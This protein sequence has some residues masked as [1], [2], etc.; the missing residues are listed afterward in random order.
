MV[1]QGTSVL[2]TGGSG[3]IG[4][5]VVRALH[6]R[7]RVLAPTH[8]ELDLSDPGATRAYLNARRPGAVVHCAVKP[9]HRAALD[10]AR[11]L[12]ANLRMFMSLARCRDLFGRYIVVSSG[13]VYDV[14]RSLVNAVEDDLGAVVPSDEHGVSKFVEAIWLADDED[15]VELRPFGVYGP[16]ED[17]TIR[18]VSNAVCKALLGLPLTLRQDRRFSYVWVEDLAAVILA[19]LEGS[20]GPGAYNVTS[21]EDPGLRKIADLVL[22]VTDR[23]DLPI[24]VALEDEGL[25]YTGSSRKLGE[26]LPGLRMTA[27]RAGIERL[28]D[29]YRERLDSI[30]RESLLQDR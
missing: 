27:M 15:A 22:E 5:H 28:A 29:W 18:F 11:L 9:G 1:A 6:D 23:Q 30:D 7:H 20:L 16:G 10:P 3:F 13:A 25:P 8:T 17:Y 26:A 19:G 4:R 21:G 14:G 2:V 24:E 12:E